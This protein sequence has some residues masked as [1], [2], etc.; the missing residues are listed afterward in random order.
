[1]TS[2]YP[3]VPLTNNSAPYSP[4]PFSGISSSPFLP[5]NSQPLIWFP[6]KGPEPFTTMVVV[7]EVISYGD[8]FGIPWDGSLLRYSVTYKTS[9]TYPNYQPASPPSLQHSTTASLFQIRGDNSTWTLAIDQVND[10]FFDEGGVWTVNLNFAMQYQGDVTD[11]QGMF[12][13][14]SSWVLLAGP[15]I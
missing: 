4:M 1:M 15:D 8:A 14:I 6:V 9:L 11:P 2:G 13:H 7:H 12:G 3:Y 5:I 10:C